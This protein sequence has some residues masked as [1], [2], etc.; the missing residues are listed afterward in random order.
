MASRQLLS[1]LPRLAGGAAL[2]VALS[3]AAPAQ[4]LS[5]DLTD[6]GPS[7]VGAAHTFTAA[8]TDA[9]GEVQY[10]WKF[11]EADE[12]HPGGA[13]IASTFRVTSRFR[14]R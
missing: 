11:S 14:S 4:A 2:G 7:L 6:P 5:V 9:R 8:V 3:W 10:Q 13:E 1:L 12:L